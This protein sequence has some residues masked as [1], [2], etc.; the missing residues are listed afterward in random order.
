MAKEVVTKCDKCGEPGDDVRTYTVRYDART[1]E[2]DLD[3]K[4]AKPLLDLIVLGRE[5]E[6]GVRRVPDTRSL[7]RRIRNAPPQPGTE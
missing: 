3:A 5:V 4:H 1:F 6:S 7:E 2:V